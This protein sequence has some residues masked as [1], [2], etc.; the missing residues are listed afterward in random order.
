MVW[1]LC[2]GGAGE[3]IGVTPVGTQG[4]SGSMLRNYS[5]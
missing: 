5:W 1:I 2:V 3:E 4:L